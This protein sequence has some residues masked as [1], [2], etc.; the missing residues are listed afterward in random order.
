MAILGGIS[1]YD[2]MDGSSKG[3]LCFVEANTVRDAVLFFICECALT[4]LHPFNL[5]SSRLLTP[6]AASTHLQSSGWWELP[7]SAEEAGKLPAFPNIRGLC[8][9]LDFHLTPCSGKEWCASGW[10]QICSCTI[11]SLKHGV[12]WNYLLVILICRN[13]S[14]FICTLREQL[15][16]KQKAGWRHLLTCNSSSETVTPAR[17]V[18]AKVKFSAQSST[19][20]QWDLQ[21][22]SCKQTGKTMYSRVVGVCAN[23]ATAF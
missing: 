2:W 20:K 7:L 21:Q 23:A 5:S 11:L 18:K 3:K 8:C 22:L 19:K 10:L 4:V 12:G 1:A 14:L 17:D 6:T 9:L 15:L 16:R 13:T